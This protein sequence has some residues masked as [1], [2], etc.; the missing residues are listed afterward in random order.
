M[1]Y[2]AQC[3]RCVEGVKSM[4]HKGQRGCTFSVLLKN[5]TISQLVINTGESV[6]S[7]RD[8][9]DW[10]ENLKLLR[11]SRYWFDILELKQWISILLLMD[12]SSACSPSLFALL[13]TPDRLNQEEMENV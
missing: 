2:P 11:P 13:A 4:C 10:T 12:H 1:L 3:V 7:P 6:D 5:Y 9:F 8:G